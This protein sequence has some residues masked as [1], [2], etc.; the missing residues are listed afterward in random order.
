MAISL[1]TTV[2][3]RKD[4]F[5]QVVGRALEHVFHGNPADAHQLRQE[6]DSL[7]DEEQLLFYHAEPLDVAADLADVTPTPVQVQSYSGL[8]QSMGWL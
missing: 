4:E 2:Y 5:W 3:P 6:I 7:S 1:L 8:A